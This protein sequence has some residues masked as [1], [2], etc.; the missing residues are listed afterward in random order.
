MSPM[1]EHRCPYSGAQRKADLI[2]MCMLKG[3]E[4]NRHQW[5]TL[6]AANGFQLSKT[7]RTRTPFY[8]TLAVPS[9]VEL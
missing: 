6:F 8:I 4:R 9:P 3:K 1:K 5:Q 2:M 7:I